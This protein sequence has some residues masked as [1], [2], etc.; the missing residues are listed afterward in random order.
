M[1]STGCSAAGVSLAFG[2]GLALLKEV[3]CKRCFDCGVLDGVPWTD[4]GLDEGV[5]AMEES[6]EGNTIFLVLSGFFR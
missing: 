2:D 5:G 3:K 4:A 1:T 6:P